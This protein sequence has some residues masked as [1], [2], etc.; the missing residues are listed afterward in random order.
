MEKLHD[1]SFM[2]PICIGLF[3]AIVMLQSGL[4]KVINYKGNVSWLKEHFS[5]TFL[6]G[7]VPML[8]AVLAI[9]ELLAGLSSLAGIFVFVIKGSSFWIIQGVILSLL[10]LL[11]LIFGQ[12]IAQEYDGAQTIAI[13]FGV[14]LLSAL[15][16]IN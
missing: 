10:S 5:K 6:G 13:Y 11:M 2:L 12:R 16:L 4:D 9:F 8:V 7:M 3:W 14:A 15:V 1:L